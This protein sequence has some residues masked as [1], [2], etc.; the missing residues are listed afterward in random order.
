MKRIKKLIALLLAVTLITPSFAYGVLAYEEWVD[1]TTISVIGTAEVGNTLYARIGGEEPEGVIFEWRRSDSCED[2]ND[3]TP[4]EGEKESS[5]V[6]SEDDIGKCIYVIIH[7]DG[8]TYESFYQS[9]SDKTSFVIGNTDNDGDIE[10]LA[11]SKPDNGVAVSETIDTPPENSNN[12]LDLDLDQNGEWTFENVIFTH[13]EVQILKKVWNE[14][15]DKIGQITD[16]HAA[17]LKQLC[18]VYKEVN[19][20]QDNKTPVEKENNTSGFPVEGEWEYDGELFSADEVAYFHSLWDG[21]EDIEAVIATYSGED[22]LLICIEQGLR[23][24]E[25]SLLSLLPVNQDTDDVVLPQNGTWKYQGITFTSEQV[26]RLNNYFRDRDRKLSDYTVSSLLDICHCVKDRYYTSYREPLYGETGNIIV[27]TGKLPKSGEWTFQGVTFTYA[28]VKFLN[29]EFEYSGNSAEKASHYSAKELVKLCEENGLRGHTGTP[30]NQEVE[31]SEHTI[32]G[33]VVYDTYKTGNV[34]SVLGAKESDKCTWYRVS[35]RDEYDRI[36]SNNIVAENSKTYS[37]SKND[38]GKYFFAVLNDNKKTNL[39]GAMHNTY[40]SINDVGQKIVGRPEEYDD[41]SVSTLSLAPKK[42]RSSEDITKVTWYCVP[43]LSTYEQLSSYEQANNYLVGQ[44]R[45]Y[46]VSESDVGKYIFAVYEKCNTDVRQYKTDLVGPIRSIS[47]VGADWLATP[48]EMIIT[49]SSAN[50]ARA[51]GSTL[52]LLNVSNLSKCTWYRSRTKESA[53]EANS[54]ASVDRLADVS[55]A[56]D[57]TDR[58]GVSASDINYYMF[59]VYSNRR[60]ENIYYKSNIIGPMFDYYNTRW[61]TSQNEYITG[62]PESYFQSDKCTYKINK[63]TYRTNWYSVPSVDIYN[64]MN[65]YSSAETYKVSTMTSYKCT[66]SDVGKYIFAVYELDSGGDK[67]YKSELIGPITYREVESVEWMNAPNRMRVASGNMRVISVDGENRYV[68]GSALSVT[69]ISDMSRCTWYRVS[70]RREYENLHNNESARN[71]VVGEG[72]AYVPGENDDGKYVFAVVE[73]GGDFTKQYKTGLVGK[74]KYIPGY[75]SYE[76]YTSGPL[77][78]SGEWWYQGIWF[79][80]EEVAHFHALWDYTGDA[81]EMASHH[82]AMELV[83]ICVVDGLRRPGD[84]IY[85]PGTQHNDNNRNDDSNDSSSGEDTAPPITDV[86]TI[87]IMIERDGITVA[88]VMPT[89]PAT[90]TNVQTAS[91]TK[92]NASNIA[93]KK[94]EAD[95]TTKTDNKTSENSKAELPIV[96]NNLKS[97]EPIEVTLKT[98]DKKAIVKTVSEAA[99]GS[100]ITLDMRNNTTID[101]DILEAA[102]GK[103]IDIILDMGG[104][105]WTINGKN[106][107]G[108]DLKNIDLGVQFGTN[109]IPSDKIDKLAGDKATKTISINHDGEFGFTAKL[110]INVGSENFGKYANLYYYNEKDEDLEFM[111]YGMVSDNGDVNLTFSHASDYVAIMSETIMQTVD[112]ELAGTPVYEKSNKWMYVCLAVVAMMAIAGGAMVHRKK[113]TF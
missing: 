57:T 32:T 10:N 22:L 112:E 74:F 73:S 88:Q 33:S 11:Q 68:T 7:G 2:G 29:S 13:D 30:E 8:N 79:S 12:S 63:C 6:I 100:R 15:G 66:S 108:D 36:S 61:M 41:T 104:Y 59:A 105:S 1:D 107:T 14:Q 71:Y 19:D 34:L 72:N 97:T 96:E 40:W 38:E 53:E 44:E 25:I 49:G 24:Y 16:K 39:H 110:T 101:K 94:Q 89:A 91:L 48:S 50:G 54:F 3:G 45:E 26:D 4:I 17:E 84:I 83:H 64:S 81:A 28:E 80:P 76:A 9:I 102:K 35:G 70:S 52:S 93:G 62:L 87:P 86:S 103:D 113:N 75:E 56:A 21:E 42:R 78:S 31:I 55:I 92:R 109:A 27:N 23:T 90:P 5:Y 60:N 106:I 47:E 82:S 18:E 51:V 95:T 58:Y 65:T 111:T 20:G 37:T 46:D 99:N 98:D 77:P 67:Q 85:Y 69:G 43:N